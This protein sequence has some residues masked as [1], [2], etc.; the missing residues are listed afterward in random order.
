[1]QN[2]NTCSA[3]DKCLT[4]VQKY[5]L[6]KDKKTCININEQ[7]HYK[8]ESDNLYYL[9][10]RIVDKCEKCSSFNI[11]NKCIDKYIRINNDKSICH[12]ISYINSDEYYV[13]PIDDNM[14]LKC[15]SYIKNCISCTYNGCTICEDGYIFLNDDFK[16]CI[17]KSNT[18][19]DKFFT[20]NNKTYY[21]CEDYRYNSNIQCLIKILILHLFKYK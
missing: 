2:C 10:N 18:S 13:E 4:C 11:C 19:L 12:P 3:K 7:Y 8:N 9:C 14:Y 5:G 20:E 21:S 6:Y 1:M 15:S 16:N 17:K